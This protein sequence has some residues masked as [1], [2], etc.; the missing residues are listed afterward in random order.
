MKAEKVEAERWASA[1]VQRYQA[2]E[3]NGHADASGVGPFL[4]GLSGGGS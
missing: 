1:A 3:A 4:V 2:G